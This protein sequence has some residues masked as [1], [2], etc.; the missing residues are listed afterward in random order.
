VIAIRSEKEIDLMRQANRIVAAAHKLAATMM[1]PGIRTD[2]IDRAVESLIR[3]EGGKPAF[4]GY[5]GYP[6][7][8]CISIEDQVVHGIPSARRLQSGQV[9]SIDIGASYKGYYGDAA[10]T[11]ACGGVDLLRARLMDATDLALSRAI[12]QAKAGGCL[13]DIGKIVEKTALEAGFSVVRDYVGHGIGTQMHE[14]PQVLN[15]DNHMPGPELREGMVLAIEP[16][17]NAG[18]DVVRSLSDGW[19][20]VT[21]DGKPS[22]HFEHTVVVREAGGEILSW[23]DA[24]MWGDKSD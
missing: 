1:Q 8:I 14:E 13:N 6:A 20:V 18:T 10:A 7:S 24:P 16:M 19:T 4:K 22:A 15:F 9:I 12:R 17:L 5:R 3:A 23:C 21:A 2:E 11:H